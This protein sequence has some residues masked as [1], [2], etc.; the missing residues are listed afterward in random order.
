MLAQYY[1]SSFKQLT[2][3]IAFYS[4]PHRSR[5]RRKVSIAVPAIEEETA[6][7]KS[8]SSDSHSSSSS[9]EGEKKGEE[10]SRQ[11]KGEEGADES[12]DGMT[13]AKPTAGTTTTATTATTKEEKKERKR[14]VK[15]TKPSKIPASA[16]PKLKSVLAK[17]KTVD[18][19]SG[20]YAS[21]G[22]KMKL[23]KQASA[24][25]AQGSAYI[26]VTTDSIDRHRPDNLPAPAT[27]VDVEGVDALQPAYMGMTVEQM[28]A[29]KRANAVVEEESFGDDFGGGGDFGGD[30]F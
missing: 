14:S 19:S 7:P 4:L 29:F 25:A 12:D 23:P 13:A 30:D 18:G 3:L 28:R 16:N 10:S 6:T 11:K 8:T 5:S 22:G 15:E 20:A 27:Y 9:D 26:D 17:M 24:S 2:I 1:C 21:G